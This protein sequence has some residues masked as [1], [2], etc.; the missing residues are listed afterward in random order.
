M[1]IARAG[2][3]LFGLAALAIGAVSIAGILAGAHYAPVSPFLL[4]A[5]AL[6]GVAFLFAGLLQARGRARVLQE[7]TSEMHAMTERLEASL[8]AVS[9]INGRLH[10]SEARYKGLV[11]SQG[12]AIFRRAPDSRLTYAN[13][14]FFRLFGLQPQQALGRPLPPNSIPTAAAL[15]A[16][17]AWRWDMRV[18]ATISSCA[19]PT[20][21]AGSRGKISRCATRADVSSK[22]KAW[23]ATSPNAKPWKTH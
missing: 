2:M 18:R 1:S 21:G 14:A 7:R 4:V 12:D 10:E 5:F 9:A 3:V 17:P 23:A 15:R 16:S 20:A 22:S 11:D 19:P 8:K 13:D 6:G